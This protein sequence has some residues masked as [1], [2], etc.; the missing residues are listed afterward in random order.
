MSPDIIAIQFLPHDQMSIT[1]QTVTGSLR[2]REFPITR[3]Q[4]DAWLNG[5]YIQDAFPHLS[6]DDREFLLTGMTSEEW[7][8]T[9]GE[10]DEET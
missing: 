5:A 10:D 6:P 8:A 9:F 4:W 2:T 1:V 3:D 7:D